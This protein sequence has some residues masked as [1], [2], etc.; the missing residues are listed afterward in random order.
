MAIQTVELIIYLLKALHEFDYDIYNDDATI[1]HASIP[2]F[3]Q[4][5]TGVLLPWDTATIY[6][7]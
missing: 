4:V 1:P 2:Q 6:T 5:K 7:M 3:E